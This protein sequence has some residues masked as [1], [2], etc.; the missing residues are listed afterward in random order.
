MTPMTG[1]TG[2][3]WVHGTATSPMID[4]NPLD[5]LGDQAR[6]GLAEGWTAAMIA[7]TRAALQSTASNVPTPATSAATSKTSDNTGMSQ[8]QSD[9][10]CFLVRSAVSP[11]RIFRTSARTRS[12]F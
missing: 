10:G 4:L 8:V 3:G 11:R 5:W 2:S 1:V 9:I 7:P 12:G 6:Q